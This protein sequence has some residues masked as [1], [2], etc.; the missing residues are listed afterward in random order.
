MADQGNSSGY[1]GA[2]QAAADALRGSRGG[3]GIGAGQPTMDVVLNAWRNLL[4]AYFPVAPNGEYF[5]GTPPANFLNTTA[6]P[7]DSL[8]VSHLETGAQIFIVI[9]LGAGMEARGDVM[10]DAVSR[11][12]QFVIF[13][14]IRCSRASQVGRTD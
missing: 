3:R 2:L 7:S 5:V 6:S 4:T 8:V 12:Q 13:H 10:A 14:R 1:E 9:G 11:L